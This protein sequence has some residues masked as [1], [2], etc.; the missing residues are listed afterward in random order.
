VL[1]GG[2]NIASVLVGRPAGARPAGDA[3]RFSPYAKHVRCLV[4]VDWDTGREA[5]FLSPPPSPPPAHGG[6]LNAAELRGPRWVRF[7]ARSGPH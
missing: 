1:A 5:G 2:F 3:A 6:R 7:D 4:C